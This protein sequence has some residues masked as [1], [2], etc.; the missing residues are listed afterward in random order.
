MRMHKALASIV[1]AVAVCAFSAPGLAAA[2][3]GKKLTPQQ[4][5]MA[6]CGHESKG[7]KG[8]AR[9]KF[10]RTCLKGH[11]G[12]E[13]PATPSKPGTNPGGGQ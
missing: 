3:P 10:M 5:R 9:K 11:P 7:M 8:E 4:Q 1:I 13:K 12:K 2:Q 6:R